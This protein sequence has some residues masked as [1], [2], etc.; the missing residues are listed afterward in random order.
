MRDWPDCGVIT[1]GTDDNRRQN[2]RRRQLKEQT[3]KTLNYLLVAAAAVVTL[4]VA[5]SAQAGE[6][7]YT[8]KAKALAD[9]LRKVPTVASDVNLATN[10]PIGNTKAWQLSQDFRKVPNTGPRLDLA[11]A[12]RP[13]LSPKDPRFEKA[14]RE[15]AQKQVQVAPLK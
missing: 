12:P 11:R 5:L 13:A 9:S 3:M 6:P 7:L 14:W 8:P 2:N 1:I 4:N 15:N 10:R